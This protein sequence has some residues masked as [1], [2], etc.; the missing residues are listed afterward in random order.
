MKLFLTALGGGAAVCAL[1][2]A[3][4]ALAQGQQPINVGSAANDGTGDSLRAA[5]GK[6]NSNF[7]TT[8]QK[9]NNLSDLVTPAAART[10]LGLGSAATM[11]STAFDP[12]RGGGSRPGRVGL[13]RSAAVDGVRRLGSR[14]RRPSRQPAEV[15]QSRRP[16]QRRHRPGEPGPRERRDAAKHGV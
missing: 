8:L 5:F 15:Q 6:V 7:A 13:G 10:N 1:L 3:T 2:I 12:G 4:S 14:E 9:A 16:H 11:P